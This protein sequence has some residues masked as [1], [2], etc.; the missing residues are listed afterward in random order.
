MKIL[1]YCPQYY[2]R[3]G[4]RTHARGFF[5]ALR[6]LSS[7]SRSFLYPATDPRSAEKIRPVIPAR[8]ERLWF[9]P[10]TLRKII[11]YFKSKPVLTRTL[12]N[13]LNRNGCDALVI[14][15]GVQLPTLRQIRR[16]C[17][18]TSICLEIN[19]AYFD[20][21]FSGIPLRY[22]L[23]KWEVARFN[24]ADSIVVV[25]SYLKT[26]LVERGV[27]P[28]KILVNQNGVNEVAADQNDAS[29]VRIRYGIHKNAFVIGYIGGMELF[30]RLPEVVNY[31]A[32]LR[33]AGNKDICFLVIGDGVDMPAVQA[34]IK[35]EQDVL[36]DSVKLVGWQEH[37]EIPGFLATFDIAIFAFTNPYCSPLKLFEYLGAG[38]PT[39]GPDTPAVREVFEDGVHLRLI[40]QDGSNFASTV[41]EMKAD[42]GLRARLGNNGRQL[43]LSEYTWKKNAERVV[44]HILHLQ[45]RKRNRSL[46][47]N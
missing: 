40:K 17:P 1:Y 45:H 8:W 41:M 9:F 43:V 21:Y 3:H 16:A 7:V 35:A 14:R 15:A 4:A 25:S 44:G 28:E 42:P 6:E 22:L 26:Y 23:Q 34:A 10:Q 33:R 47:M 5:N 39:I 29:N 2:S 46:E 20:E 12:I 32:E 36:G 30:R 38:V 24:Q 19:A 31:I 11:N 27:F 37:D 13:E 18:E